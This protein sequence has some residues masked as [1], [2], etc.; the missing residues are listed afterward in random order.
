MKEKYKLKYSLWYDPDGDHCVDFRWD[1]SYKLLAKKGQ[2]AER[3][4]ITEEVI[5]EYCLDRSEIWKTMYLFNNGNYLLSQ[6][7]YS[8]DFERVK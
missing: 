8:K 4:V 3:I 1:E 5:E 7:E 2:I 6:E